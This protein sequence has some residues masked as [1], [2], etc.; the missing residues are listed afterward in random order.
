MN[1]VR[2]EADA[3]IA[4]GFTLLADWMEMRKVSGSGNL[5]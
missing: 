2:T 1:E 3:E 4:D 5:P